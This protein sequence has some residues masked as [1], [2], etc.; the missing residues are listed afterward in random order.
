MRIKV[1]I[2]FDGLTPAKQEVADY[3]VG[4][5]GQR[6]IG[7]NIEITTNKAASDMEIDL[8]HLETKEQAAVAVPTIVAHALNLYIGKLPKGVPGQKKFRKKLK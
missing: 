3:L 7:S 2:Y 5:I 6:E 4:C 8:T 1:K